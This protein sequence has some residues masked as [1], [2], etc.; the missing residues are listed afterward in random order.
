M[1]AWMWQAIIEF[2][3]FC[4]VVLF[5]VLTIVAVGL[6]A[7]LAVVFFAAIMQQAKLHQEIKLQEGKSLWL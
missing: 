3:V 7:I 4:K 2:P 5:P 6:G 1:I